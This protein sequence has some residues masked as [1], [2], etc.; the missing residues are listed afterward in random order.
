[1]QMVVDNLKASGIVVVV[2]AGN[3]GSSCETVDTPSAMYEN[4]FP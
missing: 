3:S 2:S 4:S 1:M